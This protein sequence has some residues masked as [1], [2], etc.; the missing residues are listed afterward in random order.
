NR[1]AQRVSAAL[2]VATASGPLYEIDTRL[3][4]SGAQ[5]PLSV[6]LD[7]FARYQ[8][9]SAWTWEHMALTRARPIFGSPA[10]RSATADV[11]DGVLRG[12]RPTR[13]VAADAFAMR[14]EMAAN[15]PP[16]GPLDA[17]LLPGGLVDLEFAVHI[18]QLVN[19]AGFDADLARAIDLLASADLAPP[20]I[21]PA[22]HFLTRML[23]TLRLVAPDSRPP[24]PATR[25][26]IA[27]AL[28]CDDWDAVVA[29]FEATRQDVSDYLAATTGAGDDHQ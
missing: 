9:E 2:S 5:G 23:V 16:A 26:L 4:P 21:G 25:A 1:L 22:A 6:S 3:R 8:R 27:A 11:I 12:D 13:D 18:T 24:A 29:R 17:K 15:K 14:G 28:D 20:S 7:G 19:R 10:A